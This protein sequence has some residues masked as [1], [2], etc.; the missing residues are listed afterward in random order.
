MKKRQVNPAVYTREYYLTDCTGYH[1]FKRNYGRTLEPRL[2]EVVKYIDVKKGMKVLDIGCGRGELVLWAAAKGADAVG[3]DYSLDAIKLAQLALKKRKKELK[4]KASFQLVDGNE[5]KYPSNTFDLVIMTEILEHLYP[6]EQAKI[7]KNINK[8]L[9]PGGQLFFHTAPSKIFNDYTYRFWCYPISTLLVSL[10]NLFTGHKYGNLA[11][12]KEIR[13]ESHRVMHVN[14]PSYL[15][16]KRIMEKE[17]FQGE[18]KSTNVTVLKPE[19]GWK[20]KIYNFCVYL[21][22]LSKS[23]PL[24][25]IWGNDYLALLKKQ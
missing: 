3:I 15:S 20:D 21:H 12:W 18:I 23:F 17:G 8:I 16:L 11:P 2:R 9:K 22:P 14:E 25:V 1:E 13:T 4:G 5:L 19:L 7:T 24:N 6:E 10:S